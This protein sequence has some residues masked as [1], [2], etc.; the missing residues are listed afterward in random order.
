MPADGEAIKPNSSRIERRAATAAALLAVFISALLYLP[1][2]WW[3]AALLLVLFG[4][5][6]E[7]GAL[8][9]I[10]L[11]GRWSFCALTIGSALALWTME[12]TAPPS[13]VIA[14]SCGFWI[15][16]APA[17]LAGR[18]RVTSLPVLVLT[19]WVVVVPTWLALGQLQIHPPELLAVL[20]VVWLMDTG[21][22][23]AGR[24]W[25]RHKLAVSISPGK[26]WEGVAGGVA[27]VAVY[28]AVLAGSLPEWNWWEG[29]RGVILFVVVTATS[30]IGDLFESWMKRQAGVKDSGTLLPGHGGILDRIDSMTSSMPLA[31]ALLLYI[32]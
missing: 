18:W 24:T 27:L 15:F 30:V 28:Y 32:R 25:G 20:G 10:S 6:W 7:W 17:W 4:A 21:A 29:G 1:N 12:D 11:I 13:G 31:A 9:K 3:K 22:Y 14:A 26:T 16:V 8:L 2:Q 19:G 5:S 23:L